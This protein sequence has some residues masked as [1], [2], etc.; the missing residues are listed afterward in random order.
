MLLR[1]YLIISSDCIKLSI[2]KHVEQKTQ[3]IFNIYFILEGKG[4]FIINEVKEGC[5]KGDLVVIPAGTIFTYEG[6]FRLLLSCTPPWKIEQEETL[7]P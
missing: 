3:P 7:T 1:V 6:K 2:D 5:S 4:H